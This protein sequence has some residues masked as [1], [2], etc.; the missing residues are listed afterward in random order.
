MAKKPKPA[1]A[2][3]KIVLRR[4]RETLGPKTMTLEEFRTRAVLGHCRREAKD[5]DAAIRRAV[6]K[7]RERCIACLQ[8]GGWDVPLTLMDGSN[9]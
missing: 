2:G 7:E 1:T 4:V 8:H 5:H 6:K 3:E 9:P